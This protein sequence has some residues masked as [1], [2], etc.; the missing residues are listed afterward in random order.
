M[1]QM[2][3]QEIRPEMLSEN[4]SLEEL[5]RTN[6]TDLD[7]TP[8]VKEKENLRQLARLVLQP[9]RDAWGK[10]LKV[11]S[12]YRSLLVNTRVHGS[13]NSYHLRGLAADID[14]ATDLAK[15]MRLALACRDERLPV[16]EVILSKR[17]AHYWLHVAL[18]TGDDRKQAVF[19]M[20]TY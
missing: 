15:A 12:A 2:N 16:A 1:M 5:T 11:N 7:N 17:G 13:R 4:F 8:G 14:C 3:E 10:P 19:T 18:K 20:T 9:L 6:H